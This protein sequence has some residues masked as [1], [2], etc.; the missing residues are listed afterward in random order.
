MKKFI[1]GICSLLVAVSCMASPKSTKSVTVK[2]TFDAITTSGNVEVEYTGASKVSIVVKA[3]KEDLDKANFTLKN[4]TLFISTEN[5]LKDEVKV[6]VKA[7]RVCKFNASGNSEIDVES[8]VSGSKLTVNGSGNAHIEFSAGVNIPAVDITASGNSIVK[9]DEGAT[10][11]AVTVTLSGNSCTKI[12]DLNANKIDI[13]THGNSIASFKRGAI[14]TVT[15]DAQGN[16]VV[17]LEGHAGTV[18]YSASGNSIIKAEDMRANGGSVSASANSI[19]RSS[20]NVIKILK[21]DTSNVH[22]KL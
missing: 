2:G 5:E 12:P 8:N 13:N 3:A 22:N 9:I 20:I 18:S 1:T 10:C 17:K 15:A 19:I 7:P 4:G 16:S 21:G 14:N 11:D 6:Y